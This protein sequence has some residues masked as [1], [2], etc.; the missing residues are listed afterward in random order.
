[1]PHTVGGPLPVVARQGRQQQKYGE[2]GARL[3]AGC[4]PF[5]YLPDVPGP[6][7]VRVLMITSRGGKGYVFPKGGWEEDE[8]VE[9][10][11]RRETVEEAGVRGTVELPML[12]TFVF[13]SVKADKLASAA[14][15]RCVAYMFALLVSEELATWPEA[16]QRRRVW[17][18]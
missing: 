6:G 5:R 16:K 4:I 1:M 15:G 14:K 12:G 13:Q 18:S 9:N 3:V 17:V 2:D 8:S 10:A 11:A 7:G